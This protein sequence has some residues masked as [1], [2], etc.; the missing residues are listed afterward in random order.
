MIKGGGG[1][2]T[3]EKIIAAVAAN[4]F[5]SRMK[6]R[7]L[8]FSVLFHYQLK[9][10]LWREVMSLANSSNLVAALFTAKVLH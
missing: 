3:R 7:K 4:M 2:L 5:A 10:F 9:L 1:A 8:I 6:L